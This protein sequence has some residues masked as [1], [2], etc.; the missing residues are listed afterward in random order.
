[1]TPF[2]LA[3]MTKFIHI[4]DDKSSN[5]LYN[6]F[7]KKYEKKLFD[8]RKKIN[9]MFFNDHFSK[10][11]ISKKKKVS[12]PFVIK[13]TRSS[14]QDFTED[15]RGWEK[16]KR[17]KWT[18]DTEKR[19]KRIYYD[20]E[21]NPYQFYLGATAIEQEWRKRYLKIPPPP[22]RTIGQILQDASLSKKIR[23]DRHKGAAKYLCYPEYT[24]FSIIAKRVL[25]LD[26]IGKKFITGRTEPLNFISFSFKNPPRLRYFK[27]ILS[28][29]GN[30]IIKHSKLFFKKF[31]KPDA[32]K[33]DNGFAMTGSLTHPRVIGKVPLWFLS[34]GII[35]VYAVPRKP[36]SQASI[37][38]NN[39]VFSRKF[40]NRIEFKSIKEVDTKLEWFN[41]SSEKY[42]AY[43]KPENKKSF[44]NKF[45]SK[46]YFTR[47]TKKDKSNSIKASIDVL[48]EK[49]FLPKSYI[50]Y[51]VLAE[52]NL[53][54]EMIYIYFEKEQ[55]PKMIKK[56]TFKIN[57]KS[58]EKLKK[59]KI[60]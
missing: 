24:I 46:I 59:L 37:E 45:I 27:R 18:G 4:N 50:N 35:P 13:W 40:W 52:W 48:N 19:I 43:Q 58:K 8:L 12:R 33:M 21:K 32:V 26:F 30:E 36:F 53:K 5:Y 23:K 15:S 6:L 7:N 44:N 11:V 3:N 38:G 2:S 54:E 56:Q 14:N 10:S 49:V 39:S 60:I 1:M 34:Q 29:T 17:R 55:N 42:C 20:L 41:K 47:Q 25:E 16:G 9:E 51:F 28:E 31:E 57:Q 22:M